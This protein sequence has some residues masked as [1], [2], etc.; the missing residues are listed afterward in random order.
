MAP[1]GPQHRGSAPHL[2]EVG[3]VGLHPSLD[4]TLLFSLTSVG[5]V[6]HMG[7][8]EAIPQANEGISGQALLEGIAFKMWSGLW[9]RFIKCYFLTVICS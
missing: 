2:P 4:M 9:V 8:T 3:D 7:R 1:A 6:V 5:N